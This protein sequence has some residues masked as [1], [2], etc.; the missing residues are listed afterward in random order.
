MKNLLL[1]ALCFITLNSQACRRPSLD[2]EDT[3]KTI[4]GCA[5][6]DHGCRSNLHTTL[7][8]LRHIDGTTVPPLGL[9]PLF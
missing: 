4:P 2:R 1:L 8:K 5:W 9:A 6:T 7:Q 3:C